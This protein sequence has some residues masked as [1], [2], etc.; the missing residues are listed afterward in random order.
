MRRRAVFIAG[1]ALASS[2]VVGAPAPAKAGPI[3][4][5]ECRPCYTCDVVVAGKHVPLFPSPCPPPP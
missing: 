4:G 1:M 2:I 3:V 5:T